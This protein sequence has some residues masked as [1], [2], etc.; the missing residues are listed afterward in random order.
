MIAGSCMAGP[1][2]TGTVTTEQE[3]WSA[4]AKGNTELEL[5][6]GGYWGV[7]TKGT[8]KRPDIGFAL[9]IVRYGWMLND[10]S[11]DGFFRGN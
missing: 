7:G 8:E 4:F 11:G 9:G 10:V 6:A 1:V 5:L 3:S 2:A